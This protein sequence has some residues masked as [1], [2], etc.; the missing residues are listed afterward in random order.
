MLLGKVHACE[1]G[2]YFVDMEGNENMHISSNLTSPATCCLETTELA[3]DNL[4]YLFF[5]KSWTV[6]ERCHIM[7]NTKIVK[8]HIALGNLK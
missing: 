7:L 3:R 6:E 2:K 8:A 4:L 5:F 1:V